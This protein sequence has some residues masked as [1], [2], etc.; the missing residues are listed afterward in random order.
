MDRVLPD[1][2]NIFEFA[3]VVGDR[4]NQIKSGAPVYVNLPGADE[5]QIA[6]KEII[7]KK[8]PLSIDREVAPGSGEFE[9]WE[10]NEMSF[11]IRELVA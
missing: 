8:C 4:I 1:R 3:E 9:T 5:E 2:M 6:I 7:D 10:V 11:D